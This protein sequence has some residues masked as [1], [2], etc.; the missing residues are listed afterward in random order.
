M[1]KYGWW[2]VKFELTIE[3]EPVR[4]DDLSDATQEHIAEM[5]KQGY[6]SGEI[7]EEEDDEE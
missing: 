4:W 3:G 6:Y 5:I 7:C 2:H 1:S